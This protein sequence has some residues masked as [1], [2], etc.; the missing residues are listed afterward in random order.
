MLAVRCDLRS[1]SDCPNVSLGA[2][3]AFA[4]AAGL[5]ALGLRL[6]DDVRS[7]TTTLAVA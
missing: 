6:P 7:G 4:G 3:F 2:A 1:K 5:G